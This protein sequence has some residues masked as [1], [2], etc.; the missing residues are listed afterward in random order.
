WADVEKIAPKRTKWRVALLGESVARGF[1]YD[2]QFNPAKVLSAMLESQ[3]G[4]KNVEVVDLAKSNLSFYELRACVGQSLALAP[5]LL[6]IFAGNNWRPQLASRDIPYVQSILRQDGIPGMKAFLDEARFH[7]VR[8]LIAQVSQVLGLRKTKVIWVI[9]EFNLADWEDPASN[10]PQ[11]PGQRNQQW[12]ALDRRTAQALHEGDVALARQLAEQMMHLDGNTSSVPLR[13]LAECCKSDGDLDGARQYLELCRDAEGWD[14]SFSLS[15]RVSAVVQNALREAASL[16][17]SFVVDLPAI[18]SR[19]LGGQLPDRRIF[20][21]YCHMSAEGIN[22]AV[23][24]IA[25]EALAILVKSKVSSEDLL[26]RGSSPSEQIQGRAC[27]LAAVHNAHFYQRLDVV[28][29]WC[30]EALKH[31]PEC[32]E[33]M[34]RYIDYE[35]RNLPMMACKSGRELLELD[36]LDTAR[37][38][39]SGNVRRL[40]LTLCEAVAGSLDEAGLQVGPAIDRLR[41]EQH[42]P[43]DTP[44]ELTE[45]YYNSAVPGVAGR[46]WTSRSFPNNRGSHSD[47]TSALWDKSLFLFVARDGE[48]VVLKLAYRVPMASDGS[49]VEV[50]VNGRHVAELPAQSRWSTRDIPVDGS[51]V[52]DGVNKVLISWPT[53]EPAAETIIGRIVDELGAERL[54]RF[55]RVYGEIYTLC[56]FVLSGSGILPV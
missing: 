48:D 41:V 33:L 5:D 3:L 18:F 2:P 44:R 32:S 8:S 46:Q 25:S 24:A 28:R 20:L 17:G 12:R 51:C 50:E 29:Y 14:P 15:P 38:L 9:P 47:C 37:Y 11:L 27:F 34:T 1:F 56:A 40:D 7:A 21:D 35:T 19:H 26:R 4:P 39:A 54:P 53:D 22:L 31:W 13:V 42:S 36:E 43:C 52:V 55:G 30:D 23:A 49:L 6:V 16:P 10:V 45:F